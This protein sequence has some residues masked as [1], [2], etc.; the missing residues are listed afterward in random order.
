MFDLLLFFIILKEYG[1]KKEYGLN[2]VQSYQLIMFTYDLKVF[3]FL[4]KGCSFFL[5]FEETL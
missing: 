4:R 5:F 1:Q 3:F 2:N